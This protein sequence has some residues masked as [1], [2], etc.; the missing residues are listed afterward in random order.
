MRCLLLV[1]CVVLALLAA[2]KVFLVFKNPNVGPALMADATMLTMGAII[3]LV[4]F[5]KL[6]KK[7]TG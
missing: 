3:F 6:G 2:L 7:W 4:V 5:S 1:P